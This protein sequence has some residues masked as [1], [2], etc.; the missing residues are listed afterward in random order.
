MEGGKGGLTGDQ[1]PKGLTEKEV[2]DIAREEA[3]NAMAAL[4]AEIAN[5]PAR[6]DGNLNGLDFHQTLE[7]VAK[8]LRSTIDS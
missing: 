4:A 8:R 5:S 6:A 3:A 2:R 1:W 7:N